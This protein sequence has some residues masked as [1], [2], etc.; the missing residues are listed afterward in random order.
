VHGNGL[1]TTFTFAFTGPDT[2]DIPVVASAVTGLFPN[3]IELDLTISST[4]L[5]GVRSLQTRRF[6]ASGIRD[7]PLNAFRL[8]VQSALA[9][10]AERNP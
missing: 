4:T 1:D 8:Q 3:T 6:E 9:Q 7:V 2:G 10:L 5:P